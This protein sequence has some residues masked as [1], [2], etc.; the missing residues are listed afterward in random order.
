MKKTASRGPHCRDRLGLVPS[1]LNG[2][3]SRIPRSVRLSTGPTPIPPGSV[4]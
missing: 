1:H 3:V 2:A 4:L